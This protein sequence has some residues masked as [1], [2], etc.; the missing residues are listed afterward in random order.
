MWFRWLLEKF[1]RLQGPITGFRHIPPL[2]TILPSPFPFPPPTKHFRSSRL[3]HR[4]YWKTI[5]AQPSRMKSV[6]YL[7]KR[8][9]LLINQS[10]NHRT[11]FLC[12]VFCQLAIG[13]SFPM[14]ILIVSSLLLHIPSSTQMRMSLFRLLLYF[15]SF[16][17]SPF[18]H[19]QG[20]GKT[21]LLELAVLRLH[22][23]WN[24]QTSS[25]SS[26]SS[27]PYLILYVCPTK[28]LCREVFTSW[29]VKF[30]SC[31]LRCVVGTC[32]H[33]QAMMTNRK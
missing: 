28:A 1:L 6:S 8:A 25:S 27:F 15:F 18:S 14:N 2:I 10:Q 31:H 17:F 23:Q 32:I 20:C 4:R 30:S 12:I 33:S 19:V 11:F 7:M 3:P 13:Q 22:N 24:C 29:S 9:I 26:S 16:L 21:V 5:P